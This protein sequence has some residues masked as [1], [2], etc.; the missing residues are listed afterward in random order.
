MAE[1]KVPEKRAAYI[2]EWTKENRDRLLL[3]LPKGQKAIIKIYSEAMG[4]S[5]TYFINCA[6]DEYIQRIRMESDEGFVS[7]IDE[8]LGELKVDDVE[9]IRAARQEYENGETVSHNDINRD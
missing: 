9:A 8:R 1:K 3:R 5:T 7:M 2:E 6:I 4:R